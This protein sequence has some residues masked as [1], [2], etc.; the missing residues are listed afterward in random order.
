MSKSIAT[1]GPR[2][3]LALTLGRRI[4]RRFARQFGCWFERRIKE[5]LLVSATTRLSAALGAPRVEA[6]P[7][8]APPTLVVCIVRESAAAAAVRATRR[9]IGWRERRGALSVGESDAAGSRVEVPLLLRRLSAVGKRAV[10]V[11]RCIYARHSQAFAFAPSRTGRHFQ[12]RAT[13]HTRCTLRAMDRL[14]ICWRQRHWQGLSWRGRRRRRYA[15]RQARAARP[16]PSLRPSDPV[17]G[18]AGRIGPGGTG[19]IPHRRKSSHG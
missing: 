9:S 10:V 7:R 2:E 18:R 3:R 6:P 8:A 17:T 13:A 16:Q 4:E 19:A 5:L 11:S 1:R 14:L 15:R 12:D